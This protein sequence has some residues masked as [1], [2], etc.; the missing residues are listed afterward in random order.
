MKKKERDLFSAAKFRPSSLLHLYF[1]CLIYA[2][3]NMGRKARSRCE[4]TAATWA[5][6]MREYIFTTLGAG[7]PTLRSRIQVS[8]AENSGKSQKC[9]LSRARDSPT[10][11]FSWRRPNI[12][13]VRERGFS[14][15]PT[16]AERLM[17]QSHLLHVTALL[18]LFLCFFFI[19][20]YLYLTHIL[21]LP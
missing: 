18:S 8:A 6:Y 3:D 4:T 10:L 2:S 7:A 15:L 5:Y 9:D 1:Y 21:P 20:L 17:K 13:R 12:E 16:H 19:Y 14:R 11:S